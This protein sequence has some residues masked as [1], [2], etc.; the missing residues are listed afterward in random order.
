MYTLD[1]ETLR[2]YYSTVT[3]RI[4]IAGKDAKN[5]KTTG[6]NKIGRACPA[7]LKGS[8]SELK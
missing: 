4:I 6:S 7:T 8:N 5:V 2:L 3:G 1:R